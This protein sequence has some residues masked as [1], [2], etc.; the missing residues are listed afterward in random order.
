M[1][2]IENSPKDG[3]ALLKEG[4]DRSHV[5]WPTALGT[6]WSGL[7]LSAVLFA[8]SLAIR[9][10][11]LTL[12]PRY[13]D[14]GFEVLQGLDIASGRAFPLTGVNPYYGPLFAYFVAGLFR[15]LG[16]HL[17]TPRL[18]AALFG[19]LT[20]VVAFWLGCLVRGHVAGLVAGAVTATMPSL[21]LYTSHHGWATS[22]TPGL[23]LAMLAVLYAGATRRN[24]L[25]L[26][27]SGLLAA[28]ALQSH[29]AAAVALIGA[30]VWLVYTL[31]AREMLK[32]WGGYAA[33]ALFLLGYAP[34]IV[35]NAN[36]ANS[37]FHIAAEHTSPFA[38]TIQPTV[39]IMRATVFAKELLLTM[40]GQMVGV[41]LPSNWTLR[42]LVALTGLLVAVGLALS[43]TRD[44]LV[45]IVFVTSVVLLPLFVAPLNYRYFAFLLPLGAVAVGI[46]VEVLWQAN[47]WAHPAWPSWS[48]RLAR[49]LV[50]G[51]LG[52]QLLLS[53]STMTTYYERMVAEGRTN[54]EYF[55]LAEL[56]RSS[57]A[58]GAGLV[59]EE[60]MLNLS[61][62][63]ATQLWYAS[64]AI[65]Y[66]LTMDDCSH[67]LSSSQTI[68]SELEGHAAPIW[69]IA[70]EPS[71]ATYAP[72]LG[73]PAAGVVSPAPV[74]STLIPFGLYQVVSPWRGAPGED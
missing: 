16:V 10:P 40:G 32:G 74:A 35:A 52:V 18:V 14:E 30:L 24:S 27:L 22:L 64:H 11:G 71:S 12:I 4:A 54:A 55:R 53:W 67:V 37:I 21:V 23:V 33:L 38:P 34:V 65:D 41:G 6:P 5:L 50:L 8:V 57:G 49:A 9:L 56:A 58:C 7:L 72:Y 3:A 69:L 2:C 44:R 46:V 13:S 63:N 39:Y 68:R 17:E 59:I 47:R 61:D 31:G 45:A 15:L 28:L 42:L 51:W 1:L 60:T 43:W 62:P 70:P 73:L 36:A 19:A 66:V 29:P 20:V 48:G 26:A 25:L